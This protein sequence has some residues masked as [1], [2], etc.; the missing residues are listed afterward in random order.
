MHTYDNKHQMLSDLTRQYDQPNT[1]AIE[2]GVHEGHSIRNIRKHFTGDIY[3]FDS[4]QGLPE[5]WRIDFPKGAFAINNPPEIP[6]V[7]IIK[8]LFQNTLQ[9]FLNT[10]TKPI[11]VTHIDCDLY[12]STIYTLT[13][14][15][16]HLAQRSV[17]IF[18]EYENYPGWEHHEH[19][20]FTEWL[21]NNPHLTA[22]Q[23]SKVNQ[24][25]QA[26]FELRLT[27]G[28]AHDVKIK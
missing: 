11:S 8:G 21:T 18:D 9:P 4:F 19:K 28:N 16:P 24:G 3:G 7:T 1:I 22:T 5:D 27:P 15:T 20:A 6:N 12:S 25:E 26:A 10:L 17:I 2:L 13:H 23:I 14:I